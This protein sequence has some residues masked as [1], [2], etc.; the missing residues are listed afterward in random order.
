MSEEVERERERERER[1]Q[2]KRRQLAGAVVN[3]SAVS[4]EVRGET[5]GDR[6]PNVQARVGT[7]GEH[8]AARRE[9]ATRVY[10]A[11]VALQSSL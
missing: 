8:H 11:H 2:Y 3:T 4:D 7:A 10:V 5:S 6:V 9:E 1:A